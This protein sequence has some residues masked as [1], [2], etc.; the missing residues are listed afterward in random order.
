M[1]LEPE[2]EW[3]CGSKKELCGPEGYPN[4]NQF[5]HY[6]LSPEAGPR[7][8]KGINYGALLV[9]VDTDGIPRA[10]GKRLSMTLKE[11]GTLFFDINESDNS[12]ERADNVG[13]LDV[14]ITVLPPK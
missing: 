1:I 10:V 14:H 7:Q 5:Y 2:G 8:V 11:E 3:A 13:S 9:K 6:Y 12:R 4:D